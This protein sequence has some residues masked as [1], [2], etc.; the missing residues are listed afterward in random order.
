MAVAL[1]GTSSAL[2]RK[3]VL[4][5][6]GL[7]DESLN[8]SADWDFLRRTSKITDFGYTKDSLVMYR[9]HDNNMSAGSIVNYYKDNER[10]ILKMIHEY[11]KKS[12]PNRL[13]NLSTLVRFYLGASKASFKSKN[14]FF[15]FQFLF[16]MLLNSAE[17]S[18][19]SQ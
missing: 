16:K 7:F 15:A 13:L 8:T 1:L 2:I 11:N 10:A 19:A 9:R 12:L 17:V 18:K 6:V 3:D 14:Y 4:D 5:S